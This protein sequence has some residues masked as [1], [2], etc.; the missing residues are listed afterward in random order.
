[1]AEQIDERELQ[2][3][4]QYL[5]EYSQQAEIFTRQLQLIEEGRMEATAAIEALTDLGSRAEAAVLLQVGGGA[6]VR[7]RVESPDRVLLNIGADVIVE[8]STEQAVEYLRDRITEMEA[9]GKRVAETLERIR[10]QMNEIARRI[11]TGYQQARMAAGPQ[12][13]VREE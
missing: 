4:Q 5:N 3:L 1:M 6:S 2:S 13:Q 8:R 12:E 7:A 9:S 10:T 11:E